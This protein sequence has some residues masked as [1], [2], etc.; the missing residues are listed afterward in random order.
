MKTNFPQYVLELSIELHG[1]FIVI[2][3]YERQVD[4][5]RALRLI[6]ENNNTNIK[7]HISTV[8]NPK[9][10]DFKLKRMVY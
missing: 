10:V 8:I 2:G 1:T 4:L 3:K 9:V 6:T 7:Y 5:S